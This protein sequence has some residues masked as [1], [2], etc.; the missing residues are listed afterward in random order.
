MLIAPMSEPIP[1]IS[2]AILTHN[3]K[4]FLSDL[5]VS[6]VNQEDQNFSIFVFDN[7]SD[8]GSSEFIESFMNRQEISS[9]MIFERSDVNLGAAEGLRRLLKAS[10]SKFVCIVHG[11]DVLKSNYIQEVRKALKRDPKV[12]A[13]N[14]GL[15]DFSSQ[16]AL[17]SN[18]RIPLWTRSDNL[19]RL[20]A[21]GL[22]PG[23]MPGSVLDKEFVLSNSLLDF[24]E[25]IN[26]VE[27]WILWMR[28]V[29]SGGR[30]RSI[31]FKIYLYRIHSNQFSAMKAKNSYFFGKARSISIAE[32]K[33]ILEKSLSLSEVRYELNYFNYSEEYIRGLGRLPRYMHV[34]SMFRIVNMA[35]R[36][37]S[38]LLVV[39]DS[40]KN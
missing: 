1:L 26:G 19:N 17:H 27:D 32:S 31:K 3:Q 4:E 5:F 30:I 22:N 6:I 16:S 10:N 23:V 40:S 37:F 12:K 7:G 18:S 14:V 39:K 13:I 11:D 28:L 29:R 20:L 38:K 25:P 33:N 36:R 8:D 2:I 35:L 24:D 9:R 15:T 34:Y 21:A